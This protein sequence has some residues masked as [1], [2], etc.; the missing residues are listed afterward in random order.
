MLAKYVGNVLATILALI[1]MLPSPS[2]HPEI[3][4][5]SDFVPLLVRTWFLKIHIL[6]KYVGHGLAKILVMKHTL[7]SPSRHPEI[8]GNVDL[9]SGT[10]NI[11]DA[12]IQTENFRSH[13][14]EDGD[15][16]FDLPANIYDLT[17]SANG[18]QSQ[19]LESIEVINGQNTDNVNF[20]LIST[21]CTENELPILKI[22]LSNFP[23]PFNPNTT[24]SFNLSSIINEEI[25]LEIYNTKGQ[26]IKKYKINNGQDSIFWNGTNNLNQSVCSGIYIAKLQKNGK[27]VA[28]HKLLLLK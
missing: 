17:A 9:I 12:I 4:G 15:Y 22:S 11:T 10:M 28:T 6:T 16:Q 5:K 7:S 23:N 20:D 14:N 8:T 27:T 1:S 19:T 18:F 24:I 3:T 26:I 25:T 21:D 13:P 2:R